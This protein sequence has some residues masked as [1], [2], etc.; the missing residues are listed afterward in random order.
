MVLGVVD[1]SWWQRTALGVAALCAVVL[2]IALLLT[3]VRTVVF[4]PRAAGRRW[5]EGAGTAGSAR[6]PA[7]LLVDLQRSPAPSDG[8]DSLPAD[9]VVALRVGLPFLVLA[10]VPISTG[11][12]VGQP[13]LGLFALPLALLFDA[14]L[15]GLFA[16][17]GRDDV[18]AAAIGTRVGAAAV[19]VLVGLVL[20]AQWG[21]AAMPVIVRGQADHGLFGVRGWGSPT[22]L[23]QPLLAAVAVVSAFLALL[24]PRD[25]RPGG[26]HAV[27][28]RLA[29]ECWVVAV[30]AWLVATFVGGGAVPWPIGNAGVGHVVSVVV[31]FAKLS[32]VAVGFVWAQETWPNRPVGFVRG[33]LVAGAS[34]AVVSLGATVLLRHLF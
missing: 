12:V 34:V 30:S 1:P 25:R 10:V 9:G 16:G 26:P 13:G 31:F 4:T 32:V 29:D 28:L 6:V 20:V 27:L 18:V 5:P 33:S 19:L 17:R 3:Y 15:F 21:S 22:F 7:E 23:V 11:L 14:A 24:E 2:P 8:T